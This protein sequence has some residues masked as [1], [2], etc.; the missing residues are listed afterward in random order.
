M[1]VGEPD[2]LEDGRHLVLAVRADRA[3]DEREVDLRVGEPRAHREQPLELDELGRLE[4]LG[5]RGRGRRPSA[6]SASCALRAG[7]DAGE[8]E[9]VRQRLAAVREGGL[10]HALDVGE[11]LGQRPAAKRDERRVDVRLRPEDRPRD[12]AWKPVRSAAS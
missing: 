9:R 12:T 8:L 7:G 4:R 5:A 3:D 10:D 6:A 11:A 2:P 1:P